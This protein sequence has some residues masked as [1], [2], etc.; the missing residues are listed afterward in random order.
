MEQRT[1]VERTAISIVP[2]I[3]YSTALFADGESG[4]QDLNLRL[5]GP[6]PSA[7]ARLSYTPRLSFLF[8][9]VFLVL[10]TGE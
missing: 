8:W 4:R 2:L 3:S 9:L 6:K 10:G 5:L 1:A 7:L